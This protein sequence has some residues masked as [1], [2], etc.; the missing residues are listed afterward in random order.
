MDKKTLNSMFESLLHIGN[1]TNHWNAKMKS[2]IYG[3]SNGVH[4]FNLVKTAKKIEEVK[5]ELAELAKQGKKVLFV[6]TKLQARED[7]AKLA[8]DTNNFFVNEKWVPGL[9]TNFRTIKVRITTYLRLLKEANNGSFDVLTKK[10]KANKLLELE[11][12]DRAFKWV[13]EMKKLPDVI[14]VVDAAYE[15]QAV[16]EA[17]SLKLPI[18]AMANTN[19][20]PDLVT[21]FIPANTNSVKSLVYIANELRSVVKASGG[22]SK[23][24]FKKFTE[25]K[26]VNK[27]APKKEES[28]TEEK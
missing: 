11:K 15:A 4:V 21:N 24:T 17:N 16:R 2:Y 1:K 8:E 12:L 23:G 5:K 25:K 14:F 6:A 20:D 26:P 19:T 18:Y 3:S 22:A 28:K 27:T 13:K 7:Y 10:E 9:L